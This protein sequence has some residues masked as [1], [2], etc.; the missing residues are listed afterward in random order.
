MKKIA[1]VQKIEYFIPRVST[2]REAEKLPLYVFLNVKDFEIGVLNSDNSEVK[3]IN[4]T[5]FGE[6]NL[7]EYKIGDLVIY[8]DEI[9]KVLA[10][11]SKFDK[12]SE[13]EKSVIKRFIEYYIAKYEEA[14]KSNDD[15][16]K[17]H[18]LT[19]LRSL[20]SYIEQITFYEKFNN[21]Y[22]KK[23]D[24]KTKLVV[25]SPEYNDYYCKEN[26]KSGKHR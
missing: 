12:F 1:I 20:A 5:T 24:P 17:E 9:N 15:S 19:I 8:D 13:D 18:L 7:Q 23:V 14:V 10:M 22:L 3:S 2:I 4:T 6:I 25:G 21:G 16:K 26:G 11:K